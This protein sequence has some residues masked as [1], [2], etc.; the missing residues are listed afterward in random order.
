MATKR[1]PAPQP[2]S[3]YI[4]GFAPS[5]PETPWGEPAAY[6]G[7]NALHRLAADKPWSAWF[8]LHDIDKHHP[9]PEE[10]EDHIRWLG[11]CGVPVYMFSEH[12]AA[13]AD[14]IPTL[15]HYPR[16]EVEAVYGR[17]F[18]NSISWMIAL[19][20]YQQFQHIGVYGVDMAQDSEYGHQRP[21]CEYFLG[22][23]AGHGI[24][25]T[26][27]DT[28]DLLKT[29]FLYG[30][31]DGGPL[32]RKFESRLA[33]LLKQR[34][35]TIRQRDQAQQMILQLMGAIEDVQYWLRAWSQPGSD[36]GAATP[37]VLTPVTN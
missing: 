36:G 4:V 9:D 19:A 5:W 6:W 13:Y 14:R 29:P 16:A 23:A 8:Q 27:P 18:T 22:W 15:V 10:R 34:D 17:Y 37:A 12:A 1:T 21:S 24:S 11:S 3:V 31:E 20:I 7:L 2:K 25:I 35:E 30:L 33:D 32:R 26:I 28:S